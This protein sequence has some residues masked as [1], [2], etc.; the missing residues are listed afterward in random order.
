MYLI[1]GGQEREVAPVAASAIV[2]SA[3]RPLFIQDGG[4]CK[5][6][7]LTCCDVFVSNIGS[8]VGI[9][10]LPIGHLY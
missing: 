5:C 2:Q 1:D 4:A 10:F 3:S 6:S 7:T 9:S 8:L